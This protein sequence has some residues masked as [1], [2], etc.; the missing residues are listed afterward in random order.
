M[1]EQKKH[2]LFGTFIEGRQVTLVNPPPN[3]SDNK[4]EAGF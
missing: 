4:N 1:T 3:S 2:E